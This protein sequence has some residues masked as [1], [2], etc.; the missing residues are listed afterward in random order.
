MKN[1]TITLTETELNMVLSALGQ[2]SYAQVNELMQ[3][4]SA[5]IAPQLEPSTQASETA[6]KEV[7]G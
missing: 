3:N 2:L 5:Q 4:L 1:F 7:A 6:L